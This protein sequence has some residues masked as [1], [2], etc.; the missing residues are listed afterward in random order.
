MEEWKHTIL[1]LSGGKEGQMGEKC[2]V[3]TE[4]AGME[5]DATFAN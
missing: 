5:N 2:S 4:E 3:A 1:L